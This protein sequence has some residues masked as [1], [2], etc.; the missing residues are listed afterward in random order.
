MASRSREPAIRVRLDPSTDA[1]IAR[2]GVY[3][4]RGH[5]TFFIS[6]RTA[7]KLAEEWTNRRRILDAVEGAL[8]GDERTE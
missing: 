1:V 5:Q 7:T 6:D 8:S 4:L 2:T 3:F